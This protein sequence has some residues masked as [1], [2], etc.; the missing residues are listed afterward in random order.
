[1]RTHL[2]EFLRDTLALWK[3]QGT[4]EAGEGEAVAVVRAGD[5]VISIERTEDGPFRWRVRRMGQER[6]RGCASL[7]GVL[8]AMRTALHVDRGTPL[9]IA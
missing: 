2:Y 5:A 3:V 9:R 4:V 7:L 6:P 8:S 1:M